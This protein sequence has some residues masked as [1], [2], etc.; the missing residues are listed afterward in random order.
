MRRPTRKLPATF[1]PVNSCFRGSCYQSRAR[2]RLLSICRLKTLPMRKSPRNGKDSAS[3]F[4]AYKI[5]TDKP[6]SRPSR[7]AARKVSVQEDESPSAVQFL[8]REEHGSKKTNVTQIN[9]QQVTVKELEEL[10]RTLVYFEQRNLPPGPVLFG[11]KRYREREE[12]CAGLSALNAEFRENADADRK[13]MAGRCR[14]PVQ[15]DGAVDRVA[16]R[17]QAGAR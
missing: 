7:E 8:E 6:Y 5:A 15:T 9:G 1:K 4:A 3:S 2:P 14:G 17:C 16:Q 13:R 10:E 11:Y 12:V